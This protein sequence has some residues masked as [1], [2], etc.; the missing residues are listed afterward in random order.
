[1]EKTP[2]L[3]STSLQAVNGCQAQG[4]QIEPETGINDQPSHSAQQGVSAGSSSFARV[5][6]RML[7]SVSIWGFVDQ[8]VVSIA[9]F[10][11][12]AI[13]GRVCGSDQLGVYGLAVSLFWL[14]AGIPNALVW[15]PYTSRAP[16]LSGEMRRYYAG[17]A[18]LHV[19]VVALTIAIGFVMIGLIPWP[20]LSAST[21]FW[22]MCLALAPFSLMMMLREHLRR[23]LFAHMNTR[24]LLFL[25][26]PIALMQLGVIL[27]LVNA[28]QLTFSSA[29]IAMALPCL[30]CGVWLVRHRE[31]F[32]L[33]RKQAR[34]DWQANFQFGRWLL[35]VSIA[36]LLGD[37]SFRWLVGSL[38]GLNELG[39]FSAAFTTVMFV[40]PIML[41]V[42][43]LARSL[44]ANRLAEGSQHDLRKLAIRGT[45]HMAWIFGLLFS[46]L[47]LGG[48]FFVQLFFGNEFEGLGWVVASLCLGLYVQV[49]NFP[50]DAALS[51]LRG[52]RAMLA[53]SLVRLGLILASGVPLIA[54]YGS[55]G[56]GAA[57]AIGSF[58]AAMLQWN[59]FLRRCQ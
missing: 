18:L 16:K 34:S 36:W 7:G 12:A 25:D 48:G 45:W 4:A 56:V 31:Q 28:E 57:L 8:G 46:G 24:G 47:A 26:L 37:A 3:K 2:L 1:M 20:S 35:L 38:H 17:S 52:G 32:S 14:V 19:L 44:F 27:L 51:A 54:W 58:G 43:N 23:I 40:N 22:P 30:W 59:L 49:L 55:I 50:V 11:T 42:Q 9:S 41:T 29:L 6:S 15:T 5:V 10:A 21:W 33:S 39:Q 53:A 13:V